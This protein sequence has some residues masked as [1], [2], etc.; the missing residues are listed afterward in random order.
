MIKHQL[1]RLPFNSEDGITRYRVMGELTSDTTV[2]FKLA[3]ESATD[4]QQLP[5]CADCMGELGWAELLYGPGA[6]QCMQCGSVYVV[7]EVVE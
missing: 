1:C 6:R 4:L 2:D 7:V 5:F 3:L